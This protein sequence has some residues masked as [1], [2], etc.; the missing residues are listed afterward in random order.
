[1]VRFVVALVCGLIGF[2]ITQ[3]FQGHPIPSG[4]AIL[5]GVIVFVVVLAGGAIS[6]GDFDLGDF[7]AG[8]FGGD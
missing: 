4:F 7:D 3:Y 8:D 2:T 5:I 6:G 1:M